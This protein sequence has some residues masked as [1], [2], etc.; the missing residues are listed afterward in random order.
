[1]HKSHRS[2]AALCLVSLLGG[3][4]LGGCGS[5]KTE[6]SKED[7][8]NFKGTGVM[9]PDAA[10]AIAKQRADAQAKGGDA[11]GAPAAA[12]NVPGVDKP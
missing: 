12:S 7:E 4:L 9:P 5:E 1:M 2:I 11:P 3:A 10:A 8:K 6:M